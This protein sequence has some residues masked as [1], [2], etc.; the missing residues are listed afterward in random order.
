VDGIAD[1]RFIRQLGEA[2]YGTMFL[3]VPPPR[4]HVP[5]GHVGVKVLR[6]A[7]DDASL[8]RAT[9]EL[10]AFAAVSSAY[11]VKLLDAGRQ[12]SSF[13]YAMEY[14]AGGSL[15]AP[16]R[17]LG[18]Q[19]ILRA[20]AQAARATHALNE[21][22]LVHRGIKPSNILLS[23]DGARLA[24]LGLVQSL[25]PGQTVTGLGTVSSV[26]YLEP[27]LLSG[28]PAARTSDV[29]A[30]GVTLHRALS[31]EGVYG[32]MPTSDP[33][34]CVRRVLSSPP[35]MSSR[36]SDDAARIIARCV[37]PDP[38][39]RPQTALEFAE[40]LEPLLQQPD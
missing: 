13:F 4:L 15:A 26:E 14:C 2:G 28:N 29:W 3:A 37:E 33:L 39:D 8:R 10:R 21:A 17:A 20:V 1:Y 6:C 22:G 5:S 19:D 35:R 11:L 30:L 27:M 9:R 23:A 38:A 36:L 34:L 16:E 18:R 7:N 32:E 31:G 25:N 40:S 24:D 12:D